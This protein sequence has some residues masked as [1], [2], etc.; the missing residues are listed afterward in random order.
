[1]LNASRAYEYFTVVHGIKASTNGWYVFDC[2]ICGKH[3]KAAVNFDYRFVKCWSCNYRESILTFVRETEALEYKQ[4]VDRINSFKD[5]GM[6]FSDPT[7]N[8]Y[9]RVG[10]G[11]RSRTQVTLNLPDTYKP[12]LT[13]ETMMAERARKYL[14]GRGF[15]LEYLDECGVGYCDERSQPQD[16]F[17]HIIIPFL[18]RGRLYYY[19]GR[20]IIGMSPAK[21]KNPSVEETGVGKAEI[22]FNE[23]ILHFRKPVY[24]C[25]GVFDALTLKDAVAVMGKTLSEHQKSKLISAKYV[26]EYIVCLDSGCTKESLD[27]ALELCDHKPVK[28]L[29]L[30]L[31]DPNEMGIEYVR[32]LAAETPV[33]TFA[34][35]IE[36]RL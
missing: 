17:G 4:A 31:G 6:V 29:Q 1:M 9:R 8:P 35:L 16:Y 2:A 14:L 13:G 22:L 32:K 23:D 11:G 33:S 28:V 10:L 3:Q 34:D 21:Y 18:R 30:P 5:S 25:E 36:Q 26:P 20:D 15:D 7:E 24:I 19:L 27:I 12:I